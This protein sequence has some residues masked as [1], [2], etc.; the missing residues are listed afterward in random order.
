MRL[1]G[2]PILIVSDRGLQFISWFWV[3]FQEILRINVQLNTAFHHKTDGQSERII[4]ILKEMLR[5]CIIDFWVRWSKY[6]SSMEFA[7][8]NSYRASIDMALHET[9][10][11]PKCRL[12]V[13]WYEVS[14]RRLMGLGLEHI[15][16]YKINVIR[17]KFQ[18]SQNR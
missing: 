6:L 4:R 10:Y 3:K 18:T 13:C 12:H 8:N 5:A 11:G 7:C 15:T 2:V 9:L 17:D 1:H 14:E 16:S